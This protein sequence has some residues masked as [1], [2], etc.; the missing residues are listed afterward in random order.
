MT[1]ILGCSDHSPA[2][3]LDE[4]D[5]LREQI[6]S[7]QVVMDWQPGEDSYLPSDQVLDYL[8]HKALSPDITATLNESAA[9]AEA[10]REEVAAW[11]EVQK[12]ALVS[13]EEAW[14]R[15]QAELEGKDIITTVG[16]ESFPASIELY[17]DEWTSADEVLSRLTERPEIQGAQ[18]LDKS[19]VE[20]VLEM[21]RG[22]AHDS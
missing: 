3:L 22:S 4:I 1:L 9:E 11:P 10:L 6:M 16:P 12:V 20:A 2:S 19:D 5:A 21:L 8:E 17:L 13:K 15:W 18:A 14:A 7:G